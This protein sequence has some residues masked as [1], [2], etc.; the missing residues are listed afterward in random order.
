MATIA[1]TFAQAVQHHRRVLQADPVHADAYH[2]LG[3][4]GHQTGHHE[5]PFP[6]SG[7]PS[8]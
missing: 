3:L 7:K 1:E 4:L 5:A 2:L 6:F 8:P